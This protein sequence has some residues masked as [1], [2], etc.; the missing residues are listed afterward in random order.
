MGCTQTQTPRAGQ[1]QHSP[2]QTRPLRFLKDFRKN[3]R[4]TDATA[5]PIL[6]LVAQQMSTTCTDA[7]HR[8]LSGTIWVLTP[9]LV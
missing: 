2:K 6:A 4:I 3:I 1:T 8:A 9:D 7:H 5:T